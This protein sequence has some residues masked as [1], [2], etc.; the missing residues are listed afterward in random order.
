MLGISAAWYV[1]DFANPNYEKWFKQN[2]EAFAENRDKFEDIIKNVKSKY[3]NIYEKQNL[4]D[5][6]KKVTSEYQVELDEIGIENLEIIFD[7]KV[8]CT[9]KF[10][11]IFNVKSGYNSRK[12]NKVQI[13][14]SA[15]D[16]QTKKISIRILGIST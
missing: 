6:S 5:L 1:Y 7:E 15:C 9:E 13:I 8:Y 3:L 11:V 16:N 12:L 14:Y 10:T 4:T 2:S